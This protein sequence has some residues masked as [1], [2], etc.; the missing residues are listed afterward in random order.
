[1]RKAL[2][3]QMSVAQWAR[4]L[5]LKVKLLIQMPMV[6]SSPMWICSLNV[7]VVAF[8]DKCASK[9]LPKQ[10]NGIRVVRSILKPAL[11]PILGLIVC[12]LYVA[13]V[14]VFSSNHKSRRFS[15]REITE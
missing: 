9:F 8:S 11:T 2:L 15:P 6:G 5:L 1:M 12:S 10:N 14:A 13:V 4:A 3:I 7:K